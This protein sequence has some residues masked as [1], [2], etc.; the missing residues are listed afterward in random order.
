MSSFCSHILPVNP[1]LLQ[2]AES[3]SVA[4]NQSEL[5]DGEQSWI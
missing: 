2:P 4:C 5:G 1:L 3:V